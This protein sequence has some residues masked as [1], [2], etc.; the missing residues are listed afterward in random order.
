MRV[1][2]LF[3]GCGGMAQGF[4]NAKFNIVAAYDNWE[5]AIEVYKKNFKHPI[6]KY[7]LGSKEAPIEIYRHK[8]D[9]IIGGPPC[10]DFSSAGRENYT[11]DRAS[12]IESYQNIIEYNKPYLFV[13]ENVPRVRY[14]I[15]Y[16]NLKKHLS[17]LNYGM[18]EVI[19]N[20]AYCRVPQIRKRLFLFGIMGEKDNVLLNDIENSL[21]KKKMTMRDYFGDSLGIDYYFRIPTNYKRKAVF[22]VE[23][24]CVTIRGIDR[25]IPKNYKKHP[26][27]LADVRD[28]VR[29]L[30]VRE[31]SLVQTFPET[32]VF[33]G[34]KTN[35][36][37]M[38]GNAVPVKLAEFVANRLVHYLS[39]ENMSAFLEKKCENC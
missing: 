14:N 37:T 4:V 10:Q 21:S 32:F 7:D 9:I 31:R 39:N 22:S 34:T 5:P 18:T 17:N 38:I 29:I 12:L 13:F 28:N 27:D 24:P 6:I 23:D 36:N 30:T 19:L 8:P 11:R 25:P 16:I 26:D 20:S 2:D 3:S 33:E 1:V 35:L 15:L